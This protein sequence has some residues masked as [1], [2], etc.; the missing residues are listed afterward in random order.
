MVQLL[1]WQKNVECMSKI[2]RGGTWD[3]G[4]QSVKSLSL[5]KSSYL[6]VCVCVYIRDLTLQCWA[7]NQY[8]L[9][10]ELLSLVGS[11]NRKE[12]TVEN[13][14]N[15]KQRKTAQLKMSTNEFEFLKIEVLFFF[16]FFR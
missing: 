14:E 4:C 12:N 13:A 1:G 11:I 16:V 3:Y 5:V 2:D 10:A 9:L 15:R 6:S 8:D 7:S